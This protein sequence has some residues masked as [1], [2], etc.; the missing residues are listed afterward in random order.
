[1]EG[2]LAEERRENERLK[3]TQGAAGDMNPQPNQAEA[4]L[5]EELQEVR[6]VLKQANA[7]KNDM[8]QQL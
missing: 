8:A 3:L 6:L 2:E 4:Y 7:E 1:M 5:Q